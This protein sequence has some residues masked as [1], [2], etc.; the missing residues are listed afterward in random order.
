MRMF[1]G[2]KKIQKWVENTVE[3]SPSDGIGTQGLFG[4][5]EKSGLQTDL[6][7]VGFYSHTEGNVLLRSC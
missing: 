5:K 1:S 6:E 4:L 2:G 7:K 3:V